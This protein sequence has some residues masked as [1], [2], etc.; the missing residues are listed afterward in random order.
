MVGE[1]EDGESS[2][3]FTK[4]GTPNN[5]LGPGAE[6]EG[7]LGIGGGEGGLQESVE[8]E[9]QSVTREKPCKADQRP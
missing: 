2:E 1:Q 6:T 4:I 5:N 7:T 3:Q 9:S 8:V